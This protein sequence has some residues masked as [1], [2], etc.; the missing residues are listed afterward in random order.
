MVDE[1]GICS[2]LLLNGCAG[3]RLVAPV[4][5]GGTFFVVKCQWFYKV[6]CH[7]CDFLP[8]F[9]K[10]PG[11]CV[12]LP[13]RP[14]RGADGLRRRLYGGVKGVGL[15]RTAFLHAGVEEIMPEFFSFPRAAHRPRVAAAPAMHGHD[16]R[17][18]V[19]APRHAC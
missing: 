12:V 11:R 6:G 16:H 17:R 4:Q 14:V 2:G 8:S 10:V 5:R 3:R 18:A 9:V 15:I 13:P 7:F 19:D 1:G